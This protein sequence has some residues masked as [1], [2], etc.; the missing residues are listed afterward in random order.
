MSLLIIRLVIFILLFWVGFRLW[1]YWQNVA[2]KN[3]PNHTLSNQNQAKN[4]QNEASQE[5][6]EAMVRCAKCKVH[7]PKSSALQAGEQYFCSREHQDSFEK[8]DSSTK[9]DSSKKE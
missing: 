8:P 7:L 3:Q 4:S 9:P 6:S 5:D 2:N 1:Q